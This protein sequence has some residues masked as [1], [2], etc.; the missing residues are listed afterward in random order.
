MK[1]DS[2]VL[3][4]VDFEATCCDQQSF[5]RAEME[6]IEIGS[7]AVD[8]ATG[9]ILSEFGTFIRPV[10]H[11]VLTGFCKSLTTITQEDVDAAATFPEALDSFAA[12]L[13]QF[14]RA[15]FCSWGDY[16]RKQLANDCD[17]HDQP[18]PFLNG[19]VSA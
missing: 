9:D 8:A 14:D 18:F 6:I 15:V 1:E 13:R 4:I 17:F 2:P 11:R 3:A 19:P 5:P 16:D 12:W 7:V 10:R